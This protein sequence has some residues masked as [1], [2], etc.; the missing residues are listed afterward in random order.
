MSRSR[1]CFITRLIHFCTVGSTSR[2]TVRREM[3]G[4]N[5]IQADVLLI[6]LEKSE[7]DFSPRSATTSV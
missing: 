3:A 1:S 6:T 5:K 4:V 7:K 2:T